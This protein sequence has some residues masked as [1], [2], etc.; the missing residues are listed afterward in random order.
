DVCSSDLLS[1]RLEA[2]VATEALI[3]EMAREDTSV[4]MILRAG[5]FAQGTATAIRTQFAR[6]D[7]MREQARAALANLN[8]GF[9]LPNTGAS[10]DSGSQAAYESV[11]NRVSDSTGLQLATAARQ[12]WPTQVREELS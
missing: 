5:R 8:M 7:F 1:R 2:Y 9:N 12:D 4:D 11:R 6:T 10:F 3:N